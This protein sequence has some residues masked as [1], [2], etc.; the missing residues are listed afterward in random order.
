M[1]LG[2]PVLLV[3]FLG[4]CCAWAATREVDQK[5]LQFSV[6]SITIKA[7]ESI[8]FHNS[9]QETHNINT[10][11]D[12]FSFNVTQQPGQDRTV[13]FTTPGRFDIRCSLHRR[14]KMTVMVKP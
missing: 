1:R 3:L 5:D 6:K 11:S 2:M 12:T 4:V 9:D 14:M 8:V 7:G 10:I 13:R